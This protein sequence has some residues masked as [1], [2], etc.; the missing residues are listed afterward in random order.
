MSMKKYDVACMVVAIAGLLSGG[1][2]N[3]SG[4][5][6]RAADVRLLPVSALLLRLTAGDTRLAAF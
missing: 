3:S 4:C 6:L 5:L 1:G 2:R